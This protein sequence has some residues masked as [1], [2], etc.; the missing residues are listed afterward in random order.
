MLMGVCHAVLCFVMPCCLLL[1]QAEVDQQHT[2]IRSMITQLQQQERLMIAD[3]KAAKVIPPAN[4][5]LAA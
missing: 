1:S 3:V 2:H 5:R 4:R